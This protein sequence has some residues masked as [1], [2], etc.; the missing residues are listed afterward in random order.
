M[1]YKNKI[2]FGWLLLIVVALALIGAIASNFFASVSSKDII[3]LSAERANAQ[4]QSGGGDWDWGGVA[5]GLKDK[6]A[7]FAFKQLIKG[8]EIEPEEL[9]ERIFELRLGLLELGEQIKEIKEQE[10][11]SEFELN[12]L[13]G[14]IEARAH[15]VYVHGLL[16][17]VDEIL[18]EIDENKKLTQ[19]NRQKIIK[20]LVMLKINVDNSLGSGPTD[21]LNLVGGQARLGIGMMEC[22]D[23]MVK[24]GCRQIISDPSKSNSMKN[25]VRDLLQKI[26]NSECSYQKKIRID[27]NLRKLIKLE[28]LK[29]K[30]AEL[31]N[32]LDKI[33]KQ[34]SNN[35]IISGFMDIDIEDYY[36][37]YDS[38][39][40]YPQILNYFGSSKEAYQD[41]YERWYLWRSQ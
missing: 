38:I 37:R 31:S 32:I 21:A 20:L 14:L 22:F 34:I 36:F 16:V 11:K 9:K 10:S 12:I 3:T 39:F 18:S 40:T 27:D 28:E 7:Y 1:R 35:R 5:T 13:K 26:E 25:L 24:E 15:L 8:K 33:L 30:L 23:N 41:E 19:Q 2:S 29:A 6:A 4:K 17:K